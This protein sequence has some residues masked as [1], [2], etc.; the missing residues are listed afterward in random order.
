MISITFALPD[1]SRDLIHALR[2][3][4]EVGRVEGQ[5]VLLGNLG[6]HE[7]LVFHTGLGADLAHRRMERFLDEWPVE[8]VISSG[9]AGGLAPDLKAGALFLAENVSSPRWFAAARRV[10]G[11]EARTGAL[12][13]APATVE[14]VAERLALAQKT[15]AQAVDMESAPLARLCKARGIAFL[16]LRAISDGADEEL[17]VPFTVCFDAQT[18]KPKVGALLA[19]LLRH[20]GRIAGFIAFVNRLGQV[21]RGLTRA[22]VSL[23]A[24]EAFPPAGAAR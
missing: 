13:T 8:G 19:Y 24:A 7:C 20:P 3:A 22:L 15:G 10:L 18:Q 17:A 5:P 23:L 2:H 11:G 14:G 9:Y 4:G 16:S 12:H 6:P 21:R 1:E